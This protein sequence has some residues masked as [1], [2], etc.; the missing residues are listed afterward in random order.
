MGK[1]VRRSV[2]GEVVMT[3]SHFKLIASILGILATLGVGGLA[4]AKFV[5]RAS[6]AVTHV[7]FSKYTKEDSTIHLLQKLHTDG[8]DSVIAKQNV[9]LDEQGKTNHD[10]LCYV[11]KNPKLLCP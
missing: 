10:L 3:E 11:A 9:R 2:E 7:E 4:M 5:F 6:D 8:M 1:L